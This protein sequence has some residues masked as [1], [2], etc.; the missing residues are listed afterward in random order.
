[1]RGLE[2]EAMPGLGFYLHPYPCEAYLLPYLRGREE[3]DLVTDLPIAASSCL[4][5]LPCIAVLHSLPTPIVV[6]KTAV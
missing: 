4:L 6:Y 2:A 3:V 5:G 1:M